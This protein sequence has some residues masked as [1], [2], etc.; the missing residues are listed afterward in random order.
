MR[1]LTTKEKQIHEII[2]SKLKLEPIQ[3]LKSIG[4]NRRQERFVINEPVAYKVKGT[5]T[6]VFFGD[7]SQGYDIKKLQEHLAKLQASLS[8]QKKS[9]QENGEVI[10]ETKNTSEMINDIEK[11]ELTDI[12]TKELTS[13]LKIHDNNLKTSGDESIINEIPE[14]KIQLIVSQADVSREKA[15]KALVDSD[16]DVMQAL[17]KLTE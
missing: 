15:I 13:D 11:D 1:E 6:I 12:I 16:G 8:E 14:E 5:D 17:M 4:I 2:A 7:V 3:N 10:E 9:E